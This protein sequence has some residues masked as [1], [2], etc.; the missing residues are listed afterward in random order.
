[1][2]VVFEEIPDIGFTTKLAQNRRIK[3]EKVVDT[4]Y[5]DDITTITNNIEEAQ[6][7]PSCLVSAAQTVGLH[8]NEKTKFLT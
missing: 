3:E 7:L 5:E 1:M 6:R 8:I 2:T 4:E